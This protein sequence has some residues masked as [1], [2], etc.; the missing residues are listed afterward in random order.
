MNKTTLFGV[1]LCAAAASL[2][3]CTDDLDQ[4]GPY[5][6]SDLS[7]LPLRL[8]SANY[9]FDNLFETSSPDVE[10]GTADDAIVISIPK[11]KG[12]Y[13]FTMNEQATYTTYACNP[14]EEPYGP[15]QVPK[16]L[17]I[18]RASCRE[19]VLRLV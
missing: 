18:G 6:E 19:R 11:E 5:S 10:I 4:N 7:G 8:G 14:G 15:V 12:V 13:T 1:I 17:Q 2:C 9:V 3:S 16:T